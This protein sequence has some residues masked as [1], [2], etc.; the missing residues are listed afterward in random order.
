MTSKAILDFAREIHALAVEKGWWRDLRPAEDTFVMIHCELSEAVDEYRNGHGLTEIYYGEGE[1]PEGVPIELAD[2]VI[3]LLDAAIQY[4]DYG[5]L[6]PVKSNEA[7]ETFG[8]FIERCHEDVVCA[9]CGRQM[10]EA[11]GLFNDSYAVLIGRIETW[12]EANGMDLW[13]VCR[14]KHEYNKTRPYRHGNKRM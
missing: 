13:R 8:C 14:M 10:F 7:F 2:A 6:K 5:D 1:K 9:K 12:F 4:G 11:V 3:R